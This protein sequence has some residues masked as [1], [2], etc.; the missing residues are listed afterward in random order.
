MR[1]YYA[2]AILLPGSWIGN[3]SL[4]ST[5]PSIPPGKINRV[6]AYR[7]AILHPGHVIAVD[8]TVELLRFIAVDRLAGSKG[9]LTVS[10]DQN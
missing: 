1:I 9:V 8:R 3:R 7:S 6:P 4:R 10:R 5:Q 2:S